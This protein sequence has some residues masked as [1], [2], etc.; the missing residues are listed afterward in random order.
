MRDG[1]FKADKIILGERVEISD[2]PYWSDK[3]YCLNAVRKDIKSL[4]YIR[5]INHDIQL[6]A[7]KNNRHAIK[8]LLVKKINVS[9]EIQIEAVKRH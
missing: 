2:L 3:D 1:K 9:K 6:E 8:Y 7:V 5:D 4:K